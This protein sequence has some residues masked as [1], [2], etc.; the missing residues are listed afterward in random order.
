[1]LLIPE[2][3]ITFFISSGFFHAFKWTSPESCPPLVSILILGFVFYK[4]IRLW[5]RR[6]EVVQLRFATAALEYMPVDINGVGRGRGA[7]ILTMYFRTND[8]PEL[9]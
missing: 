3:V 7:S 5:Q 8:F 2:A 1:M 9:H 4:G 6:N